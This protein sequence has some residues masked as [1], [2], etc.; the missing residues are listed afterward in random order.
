[1]RL[2]AWLFAVPVLAQSVREDHVPLR[3]GCA[4]TAA[5]VA[6]LSKGTPVKLRYALAGQAGPC[7]AVTVEVEGKKIQGYLSAASLAGLE[8]FDAARRR[9][10]ADSRPLPT[11]GQVEQLRETVSPDA[12]FHRAIDAL[13]QGRAAEVEPILKKLG[14]PPDHRDVAV[15]RSAALL[16]LNQP[17]RALGILEAALRRYPR[18]PQLLALAGMASYKLDDARS[19]QTYWKESLDLHPDPGIADMLR[20]VQRGMGADK[21]TAKTYGSRFLL[22]YDGAVADPE[23]ARA[24]VAALEEEFSRVS[25]QLG[26]RAEE[27]LVVIVQSLQSYRSA[28]GAAEWNGGQFD[29]RIRI[30]MDR[31]KTIDPHTRQT[32]A[33]ELVHACLANLGRWPTWVHEGL[34]QKLSGEPPPPDMQDKL[35]ELTRT[36]RL[37]KLAS[38]GD[39]WWHLSAEEAR[40]R[41]AVA[42]AAADLLFRSQGAVAARNLLN[43]PESLPQVTAGLD[44]ELPAALP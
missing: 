20:R 16:E 30:P 4:D 32:L 18:D 13:Q 28:T 8:E 34:A 22:R 5:P 26:C 44:R 3:A 31:A 33:H 40:L 7:Y 29:G 41:Y 17:E 6:T 12:P 35:R 39:G 25:F 9:A 42:R 37:P 15:I 38:M 43:D 21:S 27:R 1:M 10:S 19:A 23:T 11:R 2:L 36:G 14:A 24:L